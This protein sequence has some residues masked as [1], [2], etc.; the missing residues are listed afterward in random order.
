MIICMVGRQAEAGPRRWSEPLL[1]K[2][3]EVSSS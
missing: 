2:L 3:V 1:R